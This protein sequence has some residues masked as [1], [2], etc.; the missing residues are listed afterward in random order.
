MRLVVLGAGSIGSYLGALLS[1]AND[2]TLVGR[3]AHMDAMKEGGLRISGV[4]NDTLL[5]DCATELANVRRPDLLLLTVKAYDTEAAL[6]DAIEVY[7]PDI[8]VMSVQ[9]GIGNLE[10]I[11]EMRGSIDGVYCCVTS[12]G[13]TTSSPGHIVHAGKGKTYIGSLNSERDDAVNELLLEFGNAGVEVEFT[14]D[15]HRTLW[16]KVGI[17]A[18]INPLTAILR[19]VNGELVRRPELGQLMGEIAAEVASVASAVDVRLSP[20]ELLGWARDVAASTAENRSSMLQDI[21]HGRKTEIEWIC[22]KVV[23]VGRDRGIK[24]PVNQALLN[25][26][27]AQESKD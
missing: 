8:K 2:V 19:C 7:G 3:K 21:E 10:K 5:V 4:T 22:G 6:S 25:L 14:G 1:K 27:L 17:N 26:V 13:V 20:E 11:A 18:C 16:S 9:N 24:A 12:H 23:E 15:I